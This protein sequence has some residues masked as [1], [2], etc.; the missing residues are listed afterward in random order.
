VDL[1][2]LA[3]GAGDERDVVPGGGVAGHR[4]AGADRLV[5]RV[6]VHEQDPAGRLNNHAATL[7]TRRPADAGGTTRRFA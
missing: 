7:R 6:G 2:L 5:V 4:G 1:A 3:E